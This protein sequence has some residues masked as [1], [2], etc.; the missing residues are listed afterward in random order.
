MLNLLQL[1]NSSFPLGSF[2]YSECL[3]F[4]I[5]ASQI[6]SKE[7]L[8]SFLCSDLQYGSIR[9][10]VLPL[11]KVQNYVRSKSLLEI[12]YWNSFLAGIRES[13]ELRQQS[14]QM[15]NSLLKL[16]KDLDQEKSGQV[17]ECRQVLGADCHYAIAFGI[18]VAL[19]EIEPKQA[20]LGYL[21]SWVSNLVG[22]GVKLIPL[23]QTAGQQIIYD[24]HPV[25]ER[26]AEE[27]MQQKEEHLYACSW[28][29]SLASMNH[30]TMYT[31]LFRS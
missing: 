16:L 19:W 24:L 18:A 3:E 23:G 30:E 8:L 22:A 1:S 31:R 28:G 21:H 17:K 27:L 10:D 14:I 5:D 7:S 2:N 25:I 9:L 29:L 4:V 6:Q 26:V 12:K 15:G 13:R 11:L 20:V